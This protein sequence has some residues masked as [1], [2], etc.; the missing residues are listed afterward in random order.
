MNKIGFSGS[1][2]FYAVGHFLHQSIWLSFGIRLPFGLLS[3]ILTVEML[4]SHPKLY[5]SDI[6]ISSGRI[7]VRNMVKPHNI[8]LKSCFEAN[9][10]LVRSCLNNGKGNINDVDCYGAS[11]LHVRF[12]Q[13][14]DKFSITIIVC[15]CCEQES[16]LR[17][18]QI[19]RCTTPGKPRC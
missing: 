12:N 5:Y 15:N 9:L 3:K 19:R 10:Q 16:C 6:H 13:H 7:R 2:G 17:S 4:S 18:I 14:S 1:L 8:F 11:P